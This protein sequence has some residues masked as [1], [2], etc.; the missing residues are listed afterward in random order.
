MSGTVNERI[1]INNSSIGV[2]PD[3]VQ[4]REALRRQGH[5][6]WPAMAI[7]T[8]RVIRH[9]RITVRVEVEG[10]G[11]SWR[12]PFLLSATTNTRST[13]FASGRE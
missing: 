11:R 13:D 1:F 4:E 5:R 3:I 12:T 7:A 9:F 8:L 6:K 2:Y 10:Q